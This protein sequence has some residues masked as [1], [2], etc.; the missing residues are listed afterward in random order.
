[1]TDQASASI[2]SPHNIPSWG[3]GS[4]NANIGRTSLGVC[5]L[6]RDLRVW[7]KESDEQ[8]PPLLLCI[9]CG[10]GG[11]FVEPFPKIPRF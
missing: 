8:R 1:V 9:R 5:A 7:R 6:K 3:S 11:H 4:A 2:T 10:S